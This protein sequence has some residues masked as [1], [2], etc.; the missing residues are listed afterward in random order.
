MAI[1]EKY[2]TII[3]GDS[4]GMVVFWENKINTMRKFINS[5]GGITSSPYEIDRTIV[6]VFTLLKI[7]I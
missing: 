7:Q 3:T 5:S 4:E 6:K 1:S 2:K